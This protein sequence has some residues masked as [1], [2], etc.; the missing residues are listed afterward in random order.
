MTTNSPGYQALDGFIDGKK[1]LNLLFYGWLGVKAGGNWYDVT[2]SW[3]EAT[4]RGVYCAFRWKIWFGCLFIW[5][6]MTGIPVLGMVSYIEHPEMIGRG[7]VLALICLG[8]A[9]LVG[10]PSIGAT[11]VYAVDL[12]LFQQ[13]WVYRRLYGVAWRL[14]NV[15]WAILHTILIVPIVVPLAGLVA[16]SSM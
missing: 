13:R 2:G 10:I 9:I 16:I 11:Y 5:T 4:M 7:T 1:R 3:A 14:R 6:V 8:V 12:S 15:H